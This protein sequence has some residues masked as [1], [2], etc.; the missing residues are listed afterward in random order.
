MTPSFLLTPIYLRWQELGGHGEVQQR[1]VPHA[2]WEAWRGVP[3]PRKP[4]REEEAELLRT[5][6]VPAA[7]VFSQAWQEPASKGPWTSPTE[8]L[9]C[10]G[11]LPAS[12]LQ[13]M[14]LAEVGQT[15]SPGANSGHT[16]SLGVP[17]LQPRVAFTRGTLTAEA[18]CP[19]SRPRSAGVK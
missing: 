1:G 9:L 6:G 15:K 14:S 19:V 3:S 5:Q 17:G 2:H 16:V 13:S 10:T 12:Y 7:H 8:P 4:E 18:M 11:H